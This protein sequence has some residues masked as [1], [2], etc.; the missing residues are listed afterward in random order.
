VEELAPASV[1]PPG[2]KPQKLTYADAPRDKAGALVG[3]ETQ[4][5]LADAFAWTGH[6]RVADGRVPV[7][8]GLLAPDGKRLDVTT[9][10]P[11]FRAVA[12]VKLRPTLR[13][14]FPGFV[15]P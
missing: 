9:D 8:V 1:T 3:P 10:W 12:Y 4:V 13:Q 15:W 5:K 14:K 7:R 2:G 11:A 6:P